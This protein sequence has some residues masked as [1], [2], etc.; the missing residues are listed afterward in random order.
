MT[1][2]FADKSNGL[3]EFFPWQGDTVYQYSKSQ[4]SAIFGLFLCPSLS[5]SAVIMAEMQL[6]GTL[7]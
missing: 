3:T 6:A 7:W 1:W 4:E 5:Q 2:A